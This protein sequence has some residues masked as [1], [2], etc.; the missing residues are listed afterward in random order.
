[1]T[2]VAVCSFCVSASA[3]VFGQ[4]ANTVIPPA[5]KQH[6]DA[7]AECAKS[8][9]EREA[10]KDPAATFDRIEGSLR[11]ACG[12]KI[13]LAREAL[14]RSDFSRGETKAV[15]RNA[16]T[17]MQPEFRA[18]FNQT[19][20]SEKKNHE[21]ERPAPAQPPGGEGAASQDQIKAVERE[22]NKFLSQASGDYDACLNAE[23]RNIVPTSNEPAETLTRV[24]EIKCVELEK[25]LASLGFAFY[26]AS[27]DELQTIVKA[28]LEERKK[29]LIADIVTLR[30]DLAKDAR[31]PPK[32]PPEPGAGSPSASGDQAPKQP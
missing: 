8:H 14:Y 26:G 10:K 4:S 23:T 2:C 28:P 30:T 22:R 32:G 7:Y 19:A 20:S 11:S 27:K 21:P 18:L 9:L 17:S 24:I 6:L 13:D 25:K 5:A 29:R 1:M 15:I 12:L 16:Y 31:Q 3:P